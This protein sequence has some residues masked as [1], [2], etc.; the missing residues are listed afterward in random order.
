[1]TTSDQLVFAI[2]AISEHVVL[3]DAEDRVIMANRAW[4]ELNVDIAEYAKPGTPF[5]DHIR[6]AVRHGL[7]PE[8]AGREEAWIRERMERHRNPSG[9]FEVARQN[10]RWV[11]IYEQRLSNG[12]T[13]LIVSDNTETKR[14]DRALHDSE[15]RFRALVN[16]SPTKI[17]IKDKQGRYVLINDLAAQLYGVSEEQAKNKTSHDIFPKEMADAFT[18]HDRMVMEAG[19][20]FEQEEVW[21]GPTALMTFLTV[22]F[23]IMNRAG[24]IVGVGAIGTDITDRK[25]DEEKLRRS[26][27]AL[28]DRIADLEEVQRKLELQGQDLTRLAD[29]LK[30][31]RDEAETASLAKSEFLAAMSHELRTPL[32]AIIG[33]S[34]VMKEETLGAMGSA[35]YRDYANDIN[36]SGLHLLSLINDVLD[37]SKVESGMEVLHEEVL[38]VPLVI[39]TVV[40]LVSRHAEVSG[41]V[42]EQDLPEGLPGLR[43]DERKVK[44][45]LTNLVSNAVKFTTAGGR[46]TIQARCGASGGYVFEVADTGIGIAPKDIPKALTQFVQVDSVL[47]RKHQGT[48]LGLPLA[49][50]LVELHGG[51]LQLKSELGIGTKVTLCFPAERTVPFPSLR[52]A[53]AVD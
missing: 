23:P 30:T 40:R 29:D 44:Q 48:G 3:F 17:H 32:N 13:I 38:N 4:R 19:Q 50:T 6:A 27:E 42:L 8:A 10:G 46:V 7:I 47:N 25:R 53:G 26:E 11:R 39:D 21:P 20:S 1:L 37:L 5:E 41:I 52:A 9:P 16:H 35:L 36:S 2:E 15:A 18:A 22:K 45:I 12:G 49:K 34:D 28:Q 24:G 33:F 14:I 51:T 31:A 43:A